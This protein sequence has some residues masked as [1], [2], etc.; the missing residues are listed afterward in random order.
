MDAL[1]LALVILLGIPTDMLLI[2]I[3]L[4]AV[5][6]LLIAFYLIRSSN[7]NTLKRRSYVLTSEGGE[8]QVPYGQ[9]E[10]NRLH[11]AEMQGVEEASHFSWKGHEHVSPEPQQALPSFQAPQVLS[12][13]A[14]SGPHVRRCPFCGTEA[15][16]DYVFCLRC[17]NRLSSSAPLWPQEMEKVLLASP[18]NAVTPALGAPLEK[19]EGE[20]GKAV[21]EVDEPVQ[22]VEETPTIIEVQQEESAKIEQPGYLILRSLSG[23]NLREYALD[24]PEMMI[25]RAPDCAIVLAKDRLSSR[26]HALVT[27]EKGQYRIQDKHSANGT[28]VNGGELET[29]VLLHEGDS[30][31]VGAY[32]FIFRAPRIPAHKLEEASPVVEEAAVSPTGAPEQEERKPQDDEAIP[33]KLVSSESASLPPV[34]TATPTSA[35]PTVARPITPLT[36]LSEVRFTAFH[37]QEVVIDA[38]HT[39]LVYMHIGAMTETVYRD[40]GLFRQELDEA[41]RKNSGLARQIVLSRSNITIVPECRGVLFNPKRITLRWTE[42]WHRS[43]FRF[44]ARKELAGLARSGRINVFAGP[45]LIATLRMAML[46]DHQEDASPVDAGDTTATTKLYQQIFAAYS[47]H[48]TTVARAC[49]NTYRMLGLPSPVESDKLG[50]GP[51]LHESVKNSIK[52]SEILQLFWSEHAAKSDVIT[53]EWE[54]AL[55]LNRGESFIRPVYWDVPLVPPPD[56]LEPFHFSYLPSY[57]FSSS[58]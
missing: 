22:E 4:L 57:T 21:R 23:E 50:S 45:L 11:E 2:V 28:Y 52:K 12:R 53:K 8:Q 55:Q 5:A 41:S 14:A 30:I 27:Y 42:D 44:S 29:P 13:Y 16:S 33:E 7:S 19:E 49:Q 40:A 51:D 1:E 54:Y 32:Q 46:F 26:H 15:Q 58:S 6:L 37:P 10:G 24:K 31:E 25:G 20:Q 34:T 43:I 17:G 3:L 9:S 39:L 56:T 47:L 35:T 18:D 48:D 36:P 38:W